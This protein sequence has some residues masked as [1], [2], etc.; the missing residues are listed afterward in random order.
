MVLERRSERRESAWLL[1]KL[2]GSGGC[3]FCILIFLLLDL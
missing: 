1:D 3:Y 2:N